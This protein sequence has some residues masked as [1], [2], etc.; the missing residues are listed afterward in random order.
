MMDARIRT[1]SGIS[2]VSQESRTGIYEMGPHSTDPRCEI[3]HGDLTTMATQ[4][5]AG[6]RLWLDEPTCASC[7]GNTVTSGIAI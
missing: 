4:L 3:C 6:R 2:G 1:S 7:H 5:K